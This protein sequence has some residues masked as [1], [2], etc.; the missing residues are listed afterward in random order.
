MN[1]A[2]CAFF[3]RAK[4]QGWLRLLR[5]FPQ[6]SNRTALWWK[7]FY[8]L[9]QWQLGAKCDHLSSGNASWACQKVPEAILRTLHGSVI[10]PR[11]IW[12]PTLFLFFW[13]RLFGRGHPVWV[14][15]R[16][17]IARKLLSPKC[18]ASQC[19][20]MKEGNSLGLCHLWPPGEWSLRKVQSHFGH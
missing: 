18:Q 20:Q 15:T 12:Q 1:F 16:G 6:D 8:R 3:R 11:S 19:T 7:A 17:S 5:S 9:P 4:R 2:S 13:S 14:L 10:R